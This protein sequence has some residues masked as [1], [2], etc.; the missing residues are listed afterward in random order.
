MP[1]EQYQNK[2]KQ[3]NQQTTIINYQRPNQHNKSTNDKATNK[4]ATKNNSQDTW[5]NKK[6][7]TIKKAVKTMPSRK[8]Q[9]QKKTQDNE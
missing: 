1:A 9:Q 2:D 8:R 5:Q 6:N 4:M 3:N 7:K